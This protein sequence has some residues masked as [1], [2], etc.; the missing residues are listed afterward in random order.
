MLNAIWPAIRSARPY[1][2]VVR[3]AAVLIALL[4]PIAC[5]ASTLKLTTPARSAEFTLEDLEAKLPVHVV[6]LKDP[7]DD[8]QKE[9]DG[10]RLTDVLALVDANA[11]GAA[12]ELLFT[13]KDSYA[14]VTAWSNVAAHEAFIAFQQHGSP[15]KF[16][17]VR[18]EDD[19]VIE[20]AP[21]YLVWA[22]G[23]KLKDTVPW[24]YQL[25]GIQVIDFS[26]EFAAIVPANVAPDAPPMAGFRIFKS[27][28]LSCHS[29]NGQ[30]GQI[31]PELNVP[32]NVTEY[33]HE[34]HLR[35]FIRDPGAYRRGTRM[36]QFTDLSEHDIDSV[37]SY[38]KVMKSQKSLQN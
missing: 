13:T 29:I 19:K 36:P 9:F 20:L 15:G 14:P 33:W 2:S 10:F 32:M 26:H 28:C 1:A 21:F 23:P 6:K 37:V 22:E 35:K 3:L 27:R 17:P 31:G 5:L 18:G 25:T 8:K 11:S 4:V 24:P 38:L 16:A 30:G 34:G 7:L 12:D